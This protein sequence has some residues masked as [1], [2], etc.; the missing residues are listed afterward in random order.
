MRHEKNLANPLVA[1]DLC[2]KLAALLEEPTGALLLR[3]FF[4]RNTYVL[5]VVHPLC[6]VVDNAL[7]NGKNTGMRA[8]FEPH[9]I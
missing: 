5:P 8:E 2:E 6:V 3:H 1:I 7:S 4:G 9:V